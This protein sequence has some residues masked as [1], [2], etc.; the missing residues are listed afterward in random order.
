MVLAQVIFSVSI[1]VLAVLP[2]VIAMVV[3]WSATAKRGLE[4]A[5]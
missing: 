3:D 1:I 5:Q 4:S 2:Q